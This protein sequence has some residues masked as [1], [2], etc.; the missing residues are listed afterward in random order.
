MLTVFARDFNTATPPSSGSSICFNPGAYPGTSY[1]GATG[2]VFRL[3]NTPDGFT[4]ATWVKPYWNSGQQG[5]PAIFAEMATNGMGTPPQNYYWRFGY[6]SETTLDSVFLNINWWADN[7]PHTMWV[8]APLTSNAYN[9]TITGL[10]GNTNSWNKITSNGFVHLAVTLDMAGN[11][12][13]FVTD[14]SQRFTIT[15]NGQAL[16]TF[17]YWVLPS[18]PNTLNL[19]GFVTDPHKLTIGPR[20]WNR[21]HYQDRTVFQKQYVPV[22]TINTDF[23]VGGSPADPVPS[24]DFHWNWQGNAPYTSNGINTTVVSPF[25]DPPGVAPAISTTFYV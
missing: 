18:S 1:V 7:Q 13:E 23:Y 14:I 22:H 21:S 6:D 8:H 12:P 5:A 17:E 10:S 25:F 16:E 24:S 2:N 19:N 3:P 15:W 20:Y 4:F 11:W 9:Q